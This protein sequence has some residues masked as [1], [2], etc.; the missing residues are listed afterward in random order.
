MQ[1]LACGEHV[2][3]LLSQSLPSPAA[4]QGQCAGVGSALT[5]RRASPVPWSAYSPLRTRAT[6][7]LGVLGPGPSPMPSPAQ[8]G[9]AK[10]SVQLPR[11]L[12]TGLGQ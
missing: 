12:N 8:A 6:M 9:S 1:G 11:V 10:S 7:A 3:L 4:G 5:D 2:C